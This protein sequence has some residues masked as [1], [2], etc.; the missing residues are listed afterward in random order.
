MAC[1]LTGAAG[2]CTPQPNCTTCT[3]DADCGA[4]SRCVVGQCS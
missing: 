4:G 2:T 3:T 1:S